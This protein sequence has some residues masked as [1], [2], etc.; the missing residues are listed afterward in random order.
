VPGLSVLA[1][2]YIL[3]D[4]SAATYHMFFF[5]MAAAVVIYF[6]YSMRKSKLRH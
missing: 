2:L 3:K 5:W 1:C 4:L 6:A